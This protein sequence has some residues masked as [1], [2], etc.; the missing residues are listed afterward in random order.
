MLLGPVAVRRSDGVVNMGGRKQRAALAVLAL[1]AGRVMPTERLI[2]LLWGEDP[3]LSAA[4]ALQVHISA[5]RKLLEP[6]GAPYRVLLSRASGYVLAASPDEVDV[7]RFE[8]LADRGHRELQDGDAAA[9]AQTLKEAGAL[10]RGGALA[11]LEEEPWAVAEAHSLEEL[12]VTVEEGRLEAELALGRH[13]ELVA[14]LEALVAQ[15]PLRERLC[16]QLMLALYRSGRQAGAPAVYYRCRDE[17]VE[18]LGMEPGP[19]LQLLLKQILNQDSTLDAVTTAGPQRRV[20]PPRYRNTVVGR[21]QEIEQLVDRFAESAMVTLTGPGGIG[22]TRLA[23]ELSAKLEDQF[24]DGIVFV[25]LSSVTDPALVSRAIASAL[26]LRD[27][28]ARQPMEV[29]TTHLE[30]KSLLL[31]LDNCE[32]V[33]RAA[34]SA[35]AEL[36]GQCPGLVILATSRE[37]LGVTGETIWEV[38]ALSIGPMAPDTPGSPTPIGNDAVELFRLRAEA[39]APK[40]FSWD[41]TVLVDAAMIC[42]KLDGIP[43]AIELA[44]ARVR[45]IP[46]REL[47][48]GLTE[49]FGLL[50][51]G[52]STVPR[53]R[54]LEA[55]VAWSYDLLSSV[56]QT[57]FERLSVFSGGLSADAAEAVAGDGDLPAVEVLPAVFSL[58]EKS[59]VRP[60]TGVDGSV[61]YSMLET[62]REYSR[63][64]LRVRA[65][66]SEVDRRHAAHVLELVTPTEGEVRSQRQKGWMA[67]LE[68]EHDNI[69]TA[70][71]WALERDPLLSLKIVVSLE[72]FWFRRHAREGWSWLTRAM[73]A[74]EPTGDLQARA[75]EASGRLAYRVTAEKEPARS[76]YQEAIRLWTTCQSWPR[77][78]RATCFK[79]IVESELGD[80]D[81]GRQ[82]LARA[83]DMLRP[84]DDQWNLVNA[85]NNLAYSHF[86]FGD[87]TAAKP[88][89]DE[90]L[91]I[92]RLTEDPWAIGVILDSLAEVEESLGLRAQARAHLEECVAIAGRIDDPDLA[93]AALQ[94]WARLAYADDNPALTITLMAAADVALGAIGAVPH[95]T[96]RQGSD[97]LVANARGRLS[98]EVGDDAWR[99]GETMT[100][101][102]LVGLVGVLRTGSRLSG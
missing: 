43:L 1:N 93:Y 95:A 86:E 12:R 68:E 11:G 33:V 36:L 100:L 58:V 62:I 5:L 101:S 67:M 83:V 65:D 31:I 55:T 23:V 25:D 44:A 78:A 8:Q 15:H 54:S 24:S 87:A 94:G 82:L 97:V 47:L 84:L 80:N 2:E 20:R 34:A 53:Q 22:K 48:N 85:L 76:L 102:D 91:A 61:R 49:R 79:G 50:T 64:R 39:A 73:T 57:V 32:Q 41:D 26:G 4:N 71:E 51:S 38:P 27:D 90:A 96:T 19:A 46:T 9:A 92:A 63:T 70:I 81:L 37:A 17:L 14:E 75:V 28:V 18:Q 89:L 99:Q 42:S 6:E 60:T 98:V 66:S 16:G 7:R 45:V 77:V 40:T 30:E 69:R 74:A 72:E 10:W 3:P 56:E 29:V 21:G 59:L 52:S 35:A 88:L 13:S